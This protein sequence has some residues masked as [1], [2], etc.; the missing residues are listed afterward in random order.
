MITWKVKV[1]VKIRRK[2][3][4][5]PQKYLKNLYIKKNE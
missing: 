2:N 5:K 1:D 3:K 4:E